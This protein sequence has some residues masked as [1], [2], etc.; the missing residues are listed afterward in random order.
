MKGL[1]T[2]AALAT[3]AIIGTSAFFVAAM[4][5]PDAAT[6]TLNAAPVACALPGDESTVAGL[7][8]EQT[9][10]AATIV[11]TGRGLSVPEKG[12]VVAIATAMQ[13][14]T[15]HNLPGGHLDSVGLFQQRNAWG[16]FAERTDP[17]TAATMFFTGGHGGQRGL[18]DVP[19]WEA[20]SV[21]EAAQAVQASAFP[22]AYAKWEPLAVQLVGGVSCDVVGASGPLAGNT[23]GQRAVSAAARWLGTP[24]SWGGGAFTG[25]TLGSCGPAGCQGTTTVGFDCSG[26]TLYAWYQATGGKVRLDHYTGSQWGA[27]QRIPLSQ[28]Q[29]GDLVF[30]GSSGPTSH[31]VGMYVGGGR[32]IEA[33]YTGANVRY[34]TINRG[35]LLP[36][37]GRP[38]I[39]AG[40]EAA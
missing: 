18:L 35:D 11:S 8:A 33:P 36:Y 15:L 14:S 29:P 40:G 30:Y 34:S 13:E 28:L 39:P 23:D 6:T 12:L 3:T 9:T 2:A 16:T 32:M 24:Y 25:P 37:G 20:M 31:H 4:A 21:A 10:N 17:A 22:S 26:L 27:T 38:T 19:G 1:A 5:A 7:D